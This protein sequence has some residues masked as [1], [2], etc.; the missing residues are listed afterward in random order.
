MK[1][2]VGDKFQI[3]TGCKAI[4]KNNHIIIE[5]EKFKDGD[6]LYSEDA[7]ITVIFK[8]Y[9]TNSNLFCIY[10]NNK[11]FCNKD[12]FITNSFRHATKKEKQ[13]F[14]KELAAK[15]LRWNAETKQI[16][17]IR[18]RVPY[19]EMYLMI[20]NSIT[21]DKFFVVELSDTKDLFNNQN[22]KAGNYYLLSE[23]EEAER[24]CEKINNIF[25]NRLK[26]SI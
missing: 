10:Y 3:P 24:D 9:D 7:D 25:Q 12:F 14:F 17:K 2:K 16:E 15:K 20:T 23:R 18:E 11:D 4:I 26:P 13:K 1:L 21:S 5:Q 6:I 22:Y 8:C 19:G